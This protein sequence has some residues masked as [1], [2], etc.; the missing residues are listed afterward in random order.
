VTVWAWIALALVGGAGAVVRFQIDGAISAGRR[1][2]FPLGTLVVNLS[3]A[4]AL[5][6]L[7]GAG[8]A[9]TWLFVLGTGFLGS[10]TTFSTWMFE[11]ERLAEDG[12]DAV[13]LANVG[14]GVA[15]GLLAAGAGWA[16]GAL[17]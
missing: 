14:V 9:G 16:A 13:A 11:T 5:G 6:V 3:G 8:V 10:F 17:L 7:T 12:E 15:A 2:E 4:F 1:A